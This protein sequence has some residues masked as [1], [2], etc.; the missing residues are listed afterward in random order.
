LSQTNPATII[1]T[2]TS[3]LINFLKIDRLDLL[4]SY[5][6]QFLVTDHVREEI[7]FAYPGQ[8]DCYDQGLKAGFFQGIMVNSLPELNLFGRLFQDGRLGQGECSAIA[9]AIHRGCAVALD[10]RRAI[11]EVQLI[12][13][14]LEILTTQALMV[15]LIRES[16]LTLAEADVILEDWAIN[17]R[18]KLKIKTFQELL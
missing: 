8:V 4:G 6:R 18:F 17:H 16:T 5:S 10:D 13:P 14:E 9:A 2:D 15:C 7:T 1:I 3:V 12:A 11:K